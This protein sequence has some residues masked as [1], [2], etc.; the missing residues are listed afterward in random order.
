[1]NWKCSLP[2]PNVRVG[3]SYVAIVMTAGWRS[4]TALPSGLPAAN[5]PPRCL[6]ETCKRNGIDPKAYLRHVL[7]IIADHPIN[8][9]AE[10]MPWN[11]RDKLIADKT[12][13]ARGGG[14]KPRAS[15]RRLRNSRSGFKM[16]RSL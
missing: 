14:S 5:A 16:Y 13:A 11:L 12:S 9:V 6:I 3:S 15:G 1:M 2:Q 8:R 10:L 4:A 7:A